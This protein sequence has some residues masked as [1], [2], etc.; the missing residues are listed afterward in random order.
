MR[1][2]LYTPA[3]G[4]RTAGRG[5]FPHP[6]GRQAHLASWAR[7]GISDMA[8]RDAQR[9]TP[10]W[11]SRRH[12]R[13]PASQVSGRLL[14][15]SAAHPRRARPARPRARVR[16]VRPEPVSRPAIAAVEAS[17]RPA[18]PLPCSAQRRATEARLLDALYVRDNVFPA[19]RQAASRPPARSGCSKTSFARD[20]PAPT[21]IRRRFPRSRSSRPAFARSPP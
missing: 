11:A 21:S 15:P 10:T 4:S 3:G 8:A 6:R 12:G 7:S 19:S 2:Q 5:K 17:A 14:D 16:S 13:S 9:S 20:R 1:M 18:R